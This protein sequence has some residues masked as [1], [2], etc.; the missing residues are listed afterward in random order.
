MNLG[1]W[2]SYAP[3]GIGSKLVAEDMESRASAIP[4]L[5][6]KRLIPVP[7]Q[8]RLDAQL[9]L[10][11]VVL[12][13]PNSAWPRYL[14]ILLWLPNCFVNNHLH[15]TQQRSRSLHLLNTYLNLS[16][17]ELNFPDIPNQRSK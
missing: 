12:D 10:L 1:S 15:V 14:I 7:R 11:T 16:L 6:Q 5:V 3:D 4:D 17:R 8:R 13:S 2:Q 9:H